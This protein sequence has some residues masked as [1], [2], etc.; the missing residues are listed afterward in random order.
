MPRGLAIRLDMERLANELQMSLARSGAVVAGKI[1]KAS[2]G[3]DGGRDVLD[4]Q[5]WDVADQH[6]I[7]QTLKGLQEDQKAQVCALPAR[8]R[9][10]QG[11][12]VWGRGIEG[13]QVACTDVG[14]QPRVSGFLDRRQRQ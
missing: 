11:R 6:K 2:L 3:R 4:D 7:A 10:G 12:F 13:D 14:L 5:G 8:G 1:G 9:P